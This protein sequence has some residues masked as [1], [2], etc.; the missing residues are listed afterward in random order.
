MFFTSIVKTTS[1]YI[2]IQIKPNSTSYICT[3]CLHNI[4]ENKLSLY[5]V[6]KKVAKKKSFD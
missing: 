3:S 2:Q 5:Q 6:P 1:I 4:S